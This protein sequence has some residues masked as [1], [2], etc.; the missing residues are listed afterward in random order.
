M[1]REQHNLAAGVYAELLDR[2]LSN[3]KP[4]GVAPH[5]VYRDQMCNLAD[6]PL[7]DFVKEAYQQGVFP[8]DRDM[9]TTVELFDFLKQEKRMKVTREREIANALE[10]IGGRKKPGCPVEGVGKK[11]TIW[12][13]RDYE[14]YKHL[15]AND[16]GR[17][18]QGFYT[19]ARN[20]K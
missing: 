14:N 18:Y 3:F 4:L 13:I 11:V 1:H 7:N 15:T 19:D 8:F 2:N 17:K 9:L 20:K 10:L 12:I 16:L 6:R 5:T